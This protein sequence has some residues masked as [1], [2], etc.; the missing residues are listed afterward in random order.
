MSW[1]NF[2]MKGR[3]HMEETGNMTA[4]TECAEYMDAMDVIDRILKEKEY[5]LKSISEL[6]DLEDSAALA[7]G[8]IVEF[9]ERTN[10]QMLQLAMQG[11]KEKNYS[12]V[13]VK[14]NM[15]TALQTALTEVLNSDMDSQE[16]CE[17]I[18]EIVAQMG[19]VLIV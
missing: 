7:L 13:K 1:I 14:E 18:S 12:E 2:R 10:Q 4:G 15:L 11:I 19:S 17:I 8:N 5:I 3:Y 9:R 6:K 16:M